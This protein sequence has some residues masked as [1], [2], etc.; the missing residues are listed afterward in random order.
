VEIRTYR[1]GDAPAALALLQT[2]FKRWPGPRV[3]AADRPADFFRWKH[4][5]NPQGASFILVAEEDGRLL[6]MRAY[7]PWHLN[8]DGAATGAVQAVDLATH[9]DA[10]GRGLNTQLQRHAMVEL[11]KNNAFSLGAPNDMSKSQSRKAGWRPIGRLPVWLRLQ[12]PLGVARGV[13]SIRGPSHGPPP[14]VEAATAESVLAQADWAAALPR[15]ARL[16]AGRYSA[17]G[18]LAYLRWRYQPFLADY[19]AIALAN[20]GL[21]IFRLRRRGRL[22]EAT[23]CELLADDRR[24][25]AR[26][27]RAIAKAAPFDYLSTAVLVRGAGLARSP[28]GGP[29]LGVTPYQEHVEP[30]PARRS[31]WALTLGDLERLELS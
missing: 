25:A 22:N 3:L 1:S 26:L 24:T 20:A 23:V 13:R 6:A 27:L 11:R 12:R 8:A 9:P 2:A 29:L 21:A 28:L 15:M 17:V 7:M 16:D 30:D 31:S 10:R 18:D 5:S 4:E 14:A 19:R